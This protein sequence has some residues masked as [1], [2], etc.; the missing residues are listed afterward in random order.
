MVWTGSLELWGLFRVAPTL[1]YCLVWFFFF[2]N[3]YFC[4]VGVDARSTW[5]ASAW[6]DGPG[7]RAGEQHASGTNCLDLEKGS[8][9]QVP[10]L[11]AWIKF[12]RGSIGS[13]C[14]GL[15][16]EA[17]QQ[18]LSQFILFLNLTVSFLHEGGVFPRSAGGITVPW[19]EVH[20]FIRSYDAQ[21]SGDNGQSIAWRLISLLCTSRPIRNC[22]TPL[23]TVDD[24]KIIVS[25]WPKD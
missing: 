7:V 21:P 22:T 15:Q 16:Y 9:C 6:A 14:S 8:L 4:Y 2:L 19:V 11:S 13:V 24:S 23:L 10:I 17:A 20:R 3:C 18:M 5:F 25:H 12:C 1:A